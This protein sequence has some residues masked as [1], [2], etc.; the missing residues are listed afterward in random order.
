MPPSLAN[1]LAHVLALVSSVQNMTDKQFSHSRQ[2]AQ[3]ATVG[4][5]ALRCTGGAGETTNAAWDWVME[6]AFR[7]RTD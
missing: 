5:E 6:V 1:E 4:I 3:H 7:D 2:F